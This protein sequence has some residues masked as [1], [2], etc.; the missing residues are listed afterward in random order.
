ML[1][2][3]AVGPAYFFDWRISGLSPGKPLITPF[4]HAVTAY[5]NAG[6]IYF[7]GCLSIQWLPTDFLSLIIMAA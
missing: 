6:L 5:C 7:M 2:I 1:T 4:F 3:E